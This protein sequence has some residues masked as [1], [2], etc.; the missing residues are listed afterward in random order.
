MDFV[1]VLQR[2]YKADACKAA[3]NNQKSPISRIMAVLSKIPLATISLIVINA[4]VF[5]IG[6]LTDS[7][8]QII[9]D[10]GFIPE[11]LFN[12]GLTDF[13]N[14]SGDNGFL[15]SLLL[16][17]IWGG[18][19]L[20]KKLLEFQGISLYIFCLAYSQHSFMA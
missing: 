13:N 12:A 9:R 15:S 14:Q 8:S 18:G 1:I 16:L 11:S 10:Y 5:A 7:Q 3:H 17:H 4:A 19:G 2:I 20:P 6:F